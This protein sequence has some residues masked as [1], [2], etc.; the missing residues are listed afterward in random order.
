MKTTCHCRRMS[1][2]DYFKQKGSLPD[3]KGSLARIIP[4]L[5]LQQQILKLKIY[6]PQVTKRTKEKSIS[7]KRMSPNGKTCVHHRRN[8]SRKSISRKLGVTINKSTVRGCKIVYIAKQSA[9]RLREEDNL[10]VNELQPKKERQVIASWE[11]A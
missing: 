5:Q 11:K 3:P 9:K 10:S 7:P 4:S 2:W 6:L 1:L 8:S